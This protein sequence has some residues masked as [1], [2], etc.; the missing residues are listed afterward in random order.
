MGAMDIALIN[1][2]KQPALVDK[3]N[4]AHPSPFDLK[5][6]LKSSSPFQEVA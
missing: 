2:A 1:V 5:H 4:I 6:L 3:L